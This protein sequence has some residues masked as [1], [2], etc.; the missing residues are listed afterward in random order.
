VSFHYTAWD[1]TGR[2][3]DTT[4]TRG[5]PRQTLPFKEPPGLEDA[6][7]QMTVGERAR[8]WIPPALTKG[9]VNAPAGQLCYEIQ[10]VDLKPAPKAPPPVPADVKEP[11]KDA[12][13]TAGGVFYK[14][15][16]PGTGKDHPKPTDSVKVNYTGWTT[17]GRMFDSSYV[18]GQPAQFSLQGV[19]KGWTDGIPTMVVG[20]TTRFWIPVELAYNH[21]PGRPDGM[22]VFDVELLSIEKTPA[23]PPGPPHGMPP[24]GGGAP[25]MPPGHP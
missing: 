12:K 25:G 11:P 19:I 8:F 9:S 10:L 16:K 5:Q 22:L 18:K 14:V 17:D 7:T 20:D 3:F 6:L 2:M 13:K 24:I 23:A 21:Q 4:E 15:I 1:A